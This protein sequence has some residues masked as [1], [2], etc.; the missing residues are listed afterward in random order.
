MTQRMRSASYSPSPRPIR[1][2]RRTRRGYRASGNSGTD[3]RGG[4]TQ[5][6]HRVRYGRA[7]LRQASSISVGVMDDDVLIGVEQVSE[8]LLLL[9]CRTSVYGRA[10]CGGDHEWW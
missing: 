9:L 7:P 2:R 6:L 8:I 4:Y 10:I 1:N 3:A 5:L